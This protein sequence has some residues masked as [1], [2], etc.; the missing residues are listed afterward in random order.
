[1][2]R[3]P[4]RPFEVQLYR[5]CD[6]LTGVLLSAMVVFSPWAFGTTQEWSKWTMNVCGY[7]LGALLAAKVIIR[8][9]RGYRPGRWNF[10]GLSSGFTLLLVALTAVILLYC[11]VSALNARATYNLNAFIFDYHD[12]ISWLPHSL[13][14]T[15]TWFAFW[16]YLA[17]GC[18]FWAAW[19]WLLGKS[20]GEE[21]VRV[22]AGE[23]SLSVPARFRW[24]VW[25]LSVNGFLLA[26]EGI[27]QR[28]EGSGKLLF[29]VKPRVNPGAETQFGPWAYRANAASYFNLLW[30]V[31]LGFWWTLNRAPGAGKKHHL[32][33]LFAAAMAACPLISTSRGGAVVTWVMLP[34]ALI[35][36]VGTHFVFPSGKAEKKGQRW[37]AV[38]FVVVFTAAALGL[39]LWLGWKALKPRLNSAKQDLQLREEMYDHARPMA[40]DYPVFGTG[41]GTFGWVFQLY[42]ISTETYWPAQLHNDWLET[43]ITFGYVGSGLVMLALLTVLGRYFVRGGIYAGRRFVMLTWLALAGCLLHARWD[44]PFQIYS[45]VFLF[46][47]ICAL[48]FT[49]SRHPE[50]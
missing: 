25:L 29:M 2:S 33:L 48:L 1:M 35:L 32:L 27:A 42:R 28:L 4:L 38:G 11:L 13:E 20:Q 34:A 19:D 6:E 47:L 16:S 22:G 50:G 14:S 24:L 37:M 21:R 40:R 15:S 8:T 46:L 9:L 12:C 3:L 30:P 45:I 39:G 7:L 10:R 18:S 49:V 23:A 36:L 44:F 26:T 31:C 17:L 41:P 43:R 5:V